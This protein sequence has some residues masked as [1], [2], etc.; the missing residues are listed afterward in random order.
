MAYGDNLKSL[1]VIGVY[2]KSEGYPNTLYRLRDLQTAGLFKVTEINAPM[3]QEGTQ[4][5]HGFAR[6]TRNFWRAIIAHVIVISRYLNSPRPELIYVPYPSVFVTLLAL[7]AAS[8]GSPM[9]HR[10]G[11]LYF[12]I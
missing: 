4:N 1:L 6:L 3:W 2:L 8:K 12:L 9:S 11:R 10:Y 5:R 7:M